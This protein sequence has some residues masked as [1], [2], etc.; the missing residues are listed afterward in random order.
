MNEANKNSK[1]PMD[2]AQAPQ[3]SER[4]TLLKAMGF[5][6]AALIGA[7]GMYPMTAD[8]ASPPTFTSN[9]AVAANLELKQLDTS[10]LRQLTLV[11]RAPGSTPITKMGLDS[12]G[13]AMLTP[14][15]RQLT[16]SDLEALGSD[17]SVQHPL[18]I[19]D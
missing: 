17:V 19:T 12:K 4:R 1:L 18:E 8:A 5:G 2:N 14:A 7:T 3:S 10:K 9:K 6:A 11:K 16:K 13:I 15:A